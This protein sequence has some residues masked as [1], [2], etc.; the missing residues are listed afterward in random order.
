MVIEWHIALSNVVS[1]QGEIIDAVQ[2]EH[3]A[4]L[5]LAQEL[6]DSGG[7]DME[8]RKRAAAKKD[9]VNIK[10]R[11]AALPGVAPSE[12]EIDTHHPCM[13]CHSKE[14]RLCWR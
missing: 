10:A 12:Q 14:S 5:K 13:I 7:E 6:D 11:A 9:R 3:Q 1:D 8:P 4:E 2:Q